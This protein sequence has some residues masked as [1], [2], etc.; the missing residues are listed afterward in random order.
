MPCSLFFECWILSQLFHSPFSSSSRG[1]L[2]PLHFLPLGWCYLHIWGYWYDGECFLNGFKFIEEVGNSW[3]LGWSLSEITTLG[4][5]WTKICS[6]W[7]QSPD[8]KKKKLR[9]NGKGVNEFCSGVAGSSDPSDESPWSYWLW[10]A[11]TEPIE[12]NVIYVKLGS[13]MM[14]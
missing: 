3:T 1:S 5:R 10:I 4:Y 11:N 6:S 13:M 7:A 14:L 12:K 8:E 2:L 9:N